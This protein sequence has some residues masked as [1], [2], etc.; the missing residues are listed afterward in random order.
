MQIVIVA[1]GHPS[2]RKKSFPPALTAPYLAALVEP[3]AQKIKI[4]DL[5]VQPFDYAAPLPDIALLTTTMPQSD[6]I[7][8]IAAHYKTKGVT[9]IL[10]GPH[11]TLAYHHDPR[12]KQLFDAVVLGA[13]ENALPL[14]L[15]D[16]E[17]GNLQPVYSV[18][19]TS[20]DG[21]PFSRLDLLERRKYLSST[22]IVGTRGC[23]NNCHYCAVKNIYGPKYLKRP[24]DEIIA[25]IKFQTTRPG[26]GWLS[27]KLI[28]FWDDNMAGDIDWFHALLEEMIPLKK[29]W[30]AQ[31]CLNV[32]NNT[33]TL[34]LMKAS[35]CKGLLIGL[36]SI[37]RETLKAQNKEH[38]N[39]VEDYVRQAHALLAHG[40]NFIGTLMYGFDQ[41]TRESLFGATPGMLDEM[42]LT[43]LHTHV[44]TPYPHSAY[45]QLLKREN[46]LLTLEAKYY[47]GYTVVHEPRN[48]TPLD[49]Q[50]GII[51]TR[52]KFYSFKSG[53][54]RLR[55]HRWA[56]IPEFLLWN[57]LYRKPN[58]RVIPGVCVKAWR[59]YLEQ[60]AYRR[61][62]S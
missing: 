20:L 29:W 43:L 54:K 61:S 3:F 22:A 49:L 18:P 1:P 47:N 44:A 2:H 40:I 52:R 8:H 55:K 6:H 10:G 42:G 48:I 9:S 5:A 23:P 56:Q 30:I 36:E 50:V 11:A 21:L 58:E 27:R 17:N 24:V 60:I 28:T 26:L 7:F 31:M 59:A 37:S 51:D 53:L 35:G 34:R 38:V 19:V 41:D 46:R 4:Y 16:Y 14:A 15:Q 62:A 25:E 33:E 13:G 12:I 32:A 45:Y 39:V 57:F